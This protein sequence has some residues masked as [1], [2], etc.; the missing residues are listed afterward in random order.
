MTVK[1]ILLKS[2]EEI[3]SDIQEMVNDNNK[4]IGYY[5]KKPCIVKIKDIE[6]D[7][8]EENDD[9]EA[10]FSVVIYPWMPLTTDKFIPIPAD[11]TV[12]MVEPISKVKNMYN[13]QVLEETQNDQSVDFT[14]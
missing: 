2:G 14:E 7:Q 10:R 5:L 6:I 1:L 12:T 8:T 13:D 3:V 11:W 4:V 9:N